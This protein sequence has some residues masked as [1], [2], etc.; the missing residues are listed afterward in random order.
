MTMN[1]TVNILPELSDE[2]WEAHSAELDT[3]D[4]KYGEGSVVAFQ[5]DLAFKD[6]GAGMDAWREGTDFFNGTFDDR[7]WELCSAG[8][9]FG[10]RDMQFLGKTPLSK[11]QLDEVV[12]EALKDNINLEYLNQYAVN[13]FGECCKETNPHN[14]EWKGNK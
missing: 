6:N 11:E 4:S 9:G 8:T 2:E 10:L 13:K 1:A 5:I 12:Q 7:Q 14:W 3:D